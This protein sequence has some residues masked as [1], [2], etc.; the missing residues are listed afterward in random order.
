MSHKTADDMQAEADAEARRIFDSCFYEV[1][2]AER[3]RQAER[4]LSM[5]ERQF[6]GQE[7]PRIKR[8]TEG[9]DTGSLRNALDLVHLASA[10]PSEK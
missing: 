6:K 2:V 5:P 8:T 3:L 4:V 10:K 9:V 1:H 7:S